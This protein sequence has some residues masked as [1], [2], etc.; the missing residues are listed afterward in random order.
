MWTKNLQSSFVRRYE[1]SRTQ[2]PSS[3][4]IDLGVDFHELT[5]RTTWPIFFHET[6]TAIREFL[7]TNGV[8][9]SFQEIYVG[10]EGHIK[11]SWSRSVVPSSTDYVWVRRTAP[12]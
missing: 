9:V 8:P 1:R 11:R 10:L 12:R 6:L 4:R 5:A 7:A 2:E 3:S